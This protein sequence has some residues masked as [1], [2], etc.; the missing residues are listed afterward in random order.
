MNSEDEEVTV[1]EEEKEI[2]LMTDDNKWPWLKA[3]KTGARSQIKSVLFK[4]ITALDLLRIVLRK[5]QIPIF[6][7]FNPG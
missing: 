4:N 6:L 5:S 2:V 3:G 1:T 7:A